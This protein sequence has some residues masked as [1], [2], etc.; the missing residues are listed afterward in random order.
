M[1]NLADIFAEEEARLLAERARERALEPQLTEEEI[2][3]SAAA[4]EARWGHLDDLP[5][6]GADDDD[7]EDEADD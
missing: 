1:G 2:A 6:E 7:E 4:Y 3:A 5:D